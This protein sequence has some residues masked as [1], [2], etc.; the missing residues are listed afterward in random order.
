MNKEGR[1]R[2][3]K[4]THQISLR[5]SGALLESLDQLAAHERRSRSNLIQKLL[6][7]E[8]KVRE[9]QAG[10]GQDKDKNSGSAS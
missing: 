3:R 8:I 2:G 1:P 6:E 7:D 10:Y 9:S 4:Q 5:L